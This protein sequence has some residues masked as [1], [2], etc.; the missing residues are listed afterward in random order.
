MAKQISKIAVFTALAMIF[1]YIEA[2]IPFNFGIPGVKIGIA[3][4]VIVTALYRFGVKEA[5]GISFIR[6]FLIGLLFGNIVSLIYSLSG[7]VL[8]L[9]GMIICKK[10]KLSIIGVSAVG[11]VLHNTGQ[12]SAALII[13]QSAAVT[14]YLPVLLVSGLITGILIGIVASQTN[15]ALK[16]INF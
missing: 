3:N 4:I 13:L 12:L 5:V 15:K 8:S 1:S 14:Y 16:K 9:I 10:L 6:V 11:G 2:V 7:A